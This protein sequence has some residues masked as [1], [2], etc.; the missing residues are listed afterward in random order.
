MFYNIQKKL[1]L[2]KEK[3]CHLEQ[4][5]NLLA[6]FVS[7]KTLRIGIP[8]DSLLIFPYTDQLKEEIKKIVLKVLGQGVIKTSAVKL[9]NNETKVWS[10]SLVDNSKLLEAYE[11]L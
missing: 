10:L 1:L 2:S 5:K 6:Q 7:S 8:G 3:Y 4:H 11:K 9:L